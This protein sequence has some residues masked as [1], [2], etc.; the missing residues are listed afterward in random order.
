MS[1]KRVFPVLPN[2]LCHFVVC[3]ICSSLTCILQN[4]PKKR[5]YNRF[6]IIGVMQYRL[7]QLN[8]AWKLTL[9]TS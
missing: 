7:V 1:S 3:T 4:A 2:Y 5:L 9:F 8:T 6:S